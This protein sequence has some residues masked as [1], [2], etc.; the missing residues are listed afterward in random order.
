MHIVLQFCFCKHFHQLN[1]K[2]VYFTGENS[3]TT[4]QYCS[5]IISFIV[6]AHSLRSNDVPHCIGVDD[7]S[8]VSKM[9]RSR[10]IRF[11]E[12][13][14]ARHFASVSF[15]SQSRIGC[16]LLPLRKAPSTL[17]GAGNSNPANF[18]RH[19]DDNKIIHN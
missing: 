11:Q 4:A 12:A 7:F 19:N 1:L 17:N 15:K 3:F 8:S 2:P 16:L 14:K 13:Y 6:P 5:T 9:F 10:F 18:I